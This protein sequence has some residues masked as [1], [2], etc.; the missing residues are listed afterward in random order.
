M[1]TQAQKQHRVLQKIEELQTA[2]KKGIDPQGVEYENLAQTLYKTSAAQRSYTPEEHP[3]YLLFEYRCD[4]LLYP[5][6]ITS[7]EAYLEEGILSPLIQQ[8]IMGAGKT[9]VLLPLRALKKPMD[10]YFLLLWSPKP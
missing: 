2:L 4:M 7:L 9:K 5:Q 3:E 10:T 8:M 1:A 6:Q